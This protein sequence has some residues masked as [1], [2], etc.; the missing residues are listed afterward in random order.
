MPLYQTL[1]FQQL[2]MKND[3]HFEIEIISEDNLAPLAELMTILWSDC[4]LEEALKDCVKILHS[5]EDTCFL[6]KDRENYIAFIHLALRHD[7]VE[8]S[9]SSPTAYIEGMY[10]KSKYRNLGIGQ[11]LITLA[12][13]WSKQKACKE[14][15]SD[16]ELS[17]IDS[18][19]FHKKSGFVEVNR[20]VCFIKNLNNS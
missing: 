7:Y 11:N 6:V 5:E 12:E 4:T 10:I 8:G 1:L 13:D 14:L 19:K 15:A 9:E 17:N 20:I 2:K 16:T 3:N 18:I